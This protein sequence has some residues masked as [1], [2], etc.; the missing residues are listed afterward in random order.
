MFEINSDA[1]NGR[2]KVGMSGY[3]KRVLKTEN[4]KDRLRSYG[5]AVAS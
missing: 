2:A 4:G 1:N 3:S 5:Q